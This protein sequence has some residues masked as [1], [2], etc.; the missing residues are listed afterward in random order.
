MPDYL[1]IS[2]GQWDK[3]KSREEIQDGIDR[4][5]AWYDRM[6]ETGTVK[7]GQRLAT[8]GKVV[9][10]RGVTDGPFV[11]SKE[12][13]GGYWFIVADSL[14][15]AARIIAQ[16]PTIALGLTMEVRPVEAE[17]A[18]AYRDANETPRG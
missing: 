12:I 5:Y 15:E 11:E 16:N 8:G 4:F 18:S 2:R 6:L 10:R 13:I 7:R 1:V 9:T 17:R 14:D 3:D